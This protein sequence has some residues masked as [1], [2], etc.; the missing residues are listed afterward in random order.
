MVF[1]HVRAAFWHLSSRVANPATRVRLP[2]PPPVTLSQ[3]SRLAKQKSAPETIRG[4]SSFVHPDVEGDGLPAWVQGDPVSGR[5]RQ[6]E[7][8]GEAGAL[9]R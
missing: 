3:K 8:A 5:C 4:R 6:N 7:S 9:L 1:A 2:P